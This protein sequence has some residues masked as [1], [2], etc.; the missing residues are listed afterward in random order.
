VAVAAA[1]R[2]VP[3]HPDQPFTFAEKAYLLPRGDVALQE[4]VDQWLN[5]ARN[6]GTYERFAR[7]RLG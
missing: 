2:I 7:P 5:L 3:V 1:S 6:D 4:W